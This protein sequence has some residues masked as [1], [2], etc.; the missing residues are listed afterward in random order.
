M[1]HEQPGPQPLPGWVTGCAT[2]MALVAEFDAMLGLDGVV[3]QSDLDVW[4]RHAVQAHLAHLPDYQA[5]CSG[6]QGWRE[7][8]VSPQE[9]DWARNLTA[10]DLHHRAKHV[11]AGW[12]GPEVE[13]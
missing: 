5:N 1:V 3:P 7:W 9:Q 6:C 4:L 11:L 12:W 8:S 2:C 13:F 10:L